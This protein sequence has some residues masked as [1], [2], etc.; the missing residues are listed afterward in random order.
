LTDLALLAEVVRR[1]L[2]VHTLGAYFEELAATLTGGRRVAHGRGYDVHAGDG[3]II[4]CKAST[5]GWACSQHWGRARQ[6]DESWFGLIEQHTARVVAVAVILPADVAE[7][8]HWKGYAQVKGR[9]LLRSPWAF[10]ADRADPS[11]T[12]RLNALV[13]AD[14]KR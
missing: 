13:P 4:E 8:G 5:M 12:A 1:G 9:L 7:P 11:L 3:R 10:C 6:F 2:C 14:E